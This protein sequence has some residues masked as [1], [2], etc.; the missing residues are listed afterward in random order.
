[1]FRIRVALLAGVL[2]AAA[3]VIVF[4]RITQTLQ[5]RNL[6]RVENDVIRAQK[7]LLRASRLEGF[8]L[9][10][11]AAT[12]AREDEFVQIFSKPSD[13]DRQQAAYVA[14]EVRKA[15]L[16]NRD[17]KEAPSGQATAPK[18]QEPQ[19][20]GI[21]GVVDTEGHLLA[22]DL[23]PNWRLGDDLRKD[24]PSLA[25]ALSGQPNKDLWN[26]DGGMYRI[27]AAPI[28]GAQGNVLGAVFVGFVQSNRDAIGE[29][30]VIGTDVAYFLD[31][32]IHASSFQRQGDGS[33][34]ETKEEKAVAAQLFEGQK[35]ADQVVGNH[36]ATLPFNVKIGSEEWIAAAAPLPGN[37]TASKSGFVVLSSVTAA[38]ALVVTA[39]QWVIGLGVIGLLAAI[40]AALFTAR[41]FLVPLDRIEAGV[42]E[43]I[44]GNH[45]YVFESPSPDF[46]GLANGLN[47]MVARLLGRPEPG[48]EDGEENGEGRSMSSGLEQ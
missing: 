41:R 33:S 30:D 1:M 39:S 19:K 14:V 8:D 13:K 36:Q 15:R 17:S 18:G 6:Q 24:F 27:G 40:G 2:V 23:Q 11:Q 48:E 4:G 44:N 46:E 31:G 32:K 9:A 37:A 12:F 43:V 21:I 22:R 20:V 10:N 47:V 34:S 5:E 7:E 35:F 45:D 38:E 26:L 25:V 28:R 29:R 3:T 42:S 16:E